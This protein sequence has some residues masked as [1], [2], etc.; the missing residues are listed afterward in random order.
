MIHY[1]YKIIFLDGSLKNHYYIGKR[2]Y[3]GVDI[4][5]DSYSGSGKICDD[6]FNTHKKVLNETYQKEILKICDSEQEAYDEEKR[7]L[8]D[9]FQTDVLCANFK[10]GGHGGFSSEEPWNK[11]K[12]G[13]QVAWNK[14][15]TREDERVR[16]YSDAKMGK[17]HVP[18]NKG[19]KGSQVAWNKGKFGRTHIGKRIVQMSLDGDIICEYSCIR[20]AA[21]KYKINERFISKCCKGKLETY[22]GYKWRFKNEE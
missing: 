14:G 6:Y 10:K 1:V 19:K 17:S 15:L 21:E 8:G 12:K 16:K 2:S 9:L 5:C 22:K 3:N 20:D 18:W 4:N 11:G 13:C 7:I